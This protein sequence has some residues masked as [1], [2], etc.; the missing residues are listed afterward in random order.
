MSGRKK[1][2]K[3]PKMAENIENCSNLIGKGSRSMLAS[4][5]DMCLYIKIKKLQKSGQ[6]LSKNL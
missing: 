3:T 6:N 5:F 1:I 2:I 4:Q